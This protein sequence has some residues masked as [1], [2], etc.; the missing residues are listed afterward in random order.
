MPLQTTRM[1]LGSTALE[2]SGFDLLGVFSLCFVDL[3]P[4]MCVQGCGLKLSVPDIGGHHCSNAGMPAEEVNWT[5]EDRDKAR[6]EGEAAHKSGMRLR[7]DMCDSIYLG[8]PWFNIEI[9]VGNK[10]RKSP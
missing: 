6:K 8:S 1:L 2:L 4:E 7:F 9:A 5:K 3:R 10:D